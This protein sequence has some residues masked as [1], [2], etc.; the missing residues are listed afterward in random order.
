LAVLR[1]VTYCS[2]FIEALLLLPHGGVDVVGVG[3]VMRTSLAL[4]YSSV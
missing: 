4:V 2:V 3:G 1:S